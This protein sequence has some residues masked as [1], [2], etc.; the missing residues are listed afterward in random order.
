[1]LDLALGTFATYNPQS[2]SA[3]T[4]VTDAIALMSELGIHHLPVVDSKHHVVGIVS[5][6]D[7]LA[8]SCPTTYD[9]KI[10]D[11]RIVANVMVRNVYTVDASASPKAVLQAILDHGFHCV[12]VL[13]D[14]MLLGMVTSTD[15]LRELSYGEWPV[16]ND[17]V[18]DH[19]L[20][21]STDELLFSA[22]TEVDALVEETSVVSADQTL[23]TA[24]AVML[25]YRVQEI[26]VTDQVSRPVGILRDDDILRAIITNLA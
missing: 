8:R 25:E 10:D 26:V 16:C 19:M 7:L 9:R 1:M 4:S 17:L 20:T 2:I 22:A 21:L 15:F 18:A 12:P 6:R 13:E 3:D 5:N 23:G 11:R 24:A 14:G